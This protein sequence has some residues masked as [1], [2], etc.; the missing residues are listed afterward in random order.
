[1]KKLVYLSVIV[2][3]L[4]SF[5][6]AC[7]PAP[8]PQIIKETVVVEKVVE[9]EVEVE[10][11]KVVEVEVEVEVPAEP[12]EKTI[13]EFWSTDHEV[14]RVDLYEEIAERFMAEHPD[15]DVRI[16]VIMEGEVSQRVATG[17]AANRLPDMMR[18]GIERVAA[19]AAEI[20]P[21]A[22]APPCP[23]TVGSRPSGTAPTCSRRQA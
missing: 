22:S 4:L 5:M 23:S 3:V 16:V 15:I 19:F 18:M 13:V 14:E 12:V 9:K 8:T 2:A 11:T 1:M 6:T 7:G 20:R 17:L 21:R 10:V